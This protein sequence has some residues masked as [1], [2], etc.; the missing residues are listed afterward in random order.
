M[1]AVEYDRTGGSEV[2]QL[3]EVLPPPPG[4]RQV[5]VEVHAAALN[6]KDILLR[7][8][9]LG[10]LAGPGGW[11]RRSGY[12]WAGV[13]LAVGREVRDVRP[14][15]ALF[16]MIQSGAGGALAERAAVNAD[17]CAPLPPGLSFGE[18]AALPLTALTAWQALRD[19]A[20]LQPGQRV[21]L[22]GASGGV[23][24]AAIQLA[25]VL[26]AH[27]TTLSS[28]ANRGLCR[29]LGAHVA[30]DYQHD[31][32]RQ[33][34]HAYDVV[35]DIFGTLPFARAR[36]LLAPRGVHISTIPS[37]RTLR[38]VVS[39]LLSPQRARLVV[40]RSRR[41]DLIELGQLASKGLLIPI[42]DSQFPL[43]A[44]AAAHDRVATKRARG[45]V[46]VTLQPGALPSLAPQPPIPPRSPE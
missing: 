2:L 37:A 17:E 36:G 24:V 4:T 33:P 26:G 30:L 40:V 25:R 39:T 27:V 28:A 15:D 10:W 9:K 44:V 20:R 46:I 45:K 38:D 6:P 18:A 29:E 21:L 16:G 41:S 3:R 42:V 32:P 19:I 8:G 13:A 14:G 7:S 34:G 12:D 31:S 43:T 11:P 23:G 1:K 5:L 35:F 22:N